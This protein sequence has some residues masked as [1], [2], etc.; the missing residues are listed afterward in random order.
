MQGLTLIII[1]NIQ[2]LSSSPE[3]IEMPHS[4]NIILWN[5]WRNFL[6]LC[7]SSLN[8]R[9]ISHLMTILPKTKITNSTRW[10]FPIVTLSTSETYRLFILLTTYSLKFHLSTPRFFLSLSPL[11]ESRLCLITRTTPIQI[12]S[13]P[14][15]FRLFNLLCIHHES[16]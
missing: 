16:S 7:S 11:F 14:P 13:H 6:T 8:S 3:C 12:S 9:T 4:L 15:M 10:S 5:I 2:L 1:I